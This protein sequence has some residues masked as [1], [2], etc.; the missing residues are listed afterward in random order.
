MTER[1]FTLVEV[2]VALVVFSVAA[3]SLA[4]LVTE[5]ASGARHARMASLARVEADNRIVEAALDPALLQPGQLG[6]T[7]TQRGLQLDW[8]RSV[9]LQYEGKLASI[10]VSV[11]DAG[12]QQKLA[13]RATLVRVVP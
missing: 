12:T 13:D 3:I 9:E 1:G 4:H 7:V 2:L 10:E 6:G 11:L 8:V 5:T